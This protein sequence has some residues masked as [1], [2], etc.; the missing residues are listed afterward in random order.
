MLL[1]CLERVSGEGELALAKRG[2]PGVK[3]LGNFKNWK[4]KLKPFLVN[5]RFSR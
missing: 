3:K 1:R 5:Q 4:K 2:H